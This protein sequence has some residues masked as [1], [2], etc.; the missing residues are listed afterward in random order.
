MVLRKLFGGGKTEEKNEVQDSEKASAQSQQAAPT[1]PASASTQQSAAAPA[2]GNEPPVAQHLEEAMV[3]NARH[4]SQ[5]SRNK[6]YQ[7]LLFSDLLLALAEP[8]PG[9]APA[10]AQN[11]DPN[12]MSVAILTNP[13]NVR[14]AAAFT[15]GAAARRWRPEGGQF[16][17]IRGQEIFKLLEP[18]PA[19]VIVVNPGSAPFIVL[20]KVEYKQLALGVMPQTQQSPVQVAAAPGDAGAAQPEGQN[21]AAPQEGQ[22]QVSFPPD[23]FNDQ[24]KAHA[25]QVMQLNPKIE[26]AVL[27]A[28]LPPNAQNDAWV[29]TVFLRVQG[30][31]ETNEAMQNF[32]MTVRQEISN[33]KDLFGETGFEVGVMPDPNF[34]AHMHKN[35]IILFDKNPPAMP[36]NG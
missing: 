15:S 36:A 1:T 7:E 17:S 21:G 8:Q 16:V 14:F 19:D 34:W 26:A 6:V 27:G 10:P 28:I 12:N 3:A 5:D 13:Q 4:D 35:G 20:S 2:E 11:Q 23:V 9:E 30:I 29:R 31:E 25:L 32:C 33:A 18:S 24:Q 22:M